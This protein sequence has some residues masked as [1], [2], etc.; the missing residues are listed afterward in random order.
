MYINVEVH[1][2]NKE[3]KNSLTFQLTYC[4]ILARSAI[5][6]VPP[7]SHVPVII[8]VLIFFI[9]LILVVALL[10]FMWRY[11]LLFYHWQPYRLPNVCLIFARDVFS[12]TFWWYKNDHVAKFTLAKFT[13]TK[14]ANINYLKCSLSSLWNL[15]TGT[16]Y[17]Y[18]A[19]NWR[20]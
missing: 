7:T 6:A 20:S 18:C 14:F 4:Y 16:F 9:V 12:I 13:F 19:L 15:W 8:G 1:V 3:T 11:V 17:Y 5:T 10:L 2:E